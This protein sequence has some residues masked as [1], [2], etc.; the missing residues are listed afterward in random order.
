MDLSTEAAP[1]S[2][3]TRALIVRCASPVLRA[4]TPTSVERSARSRSRFSNAV[5]GSTDPTA[6][7]GVVVNAASAGDAR[8]RRGL[9]E[10]LQRVA[11][12]GRL[13]DLVVAA[14]ARRQRAERLAGLA[15]LAALGH[16]LAHRPEIERVVA[17]LL[18]LDRELLQP[19]IGGQEDVRHLLLRRRACGG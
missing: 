3:L 19:R 2:R 14:R 5:S 6:A 15:P 10:Q 16:L 9:G 17:L 13:Q 12:L 7:A 4:I 8:R 18:D 11:G 1:T